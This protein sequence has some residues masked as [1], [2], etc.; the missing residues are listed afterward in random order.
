M[1]TSFLLVKYDSVII[2]VDQTCEKYFLTRQPSRVIS[3]NSVLWRSQKPKTFAKE[4]FL[5]IPLFKFQF[6]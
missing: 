6:H 4:K 5:K 1:R 3:E 2:D